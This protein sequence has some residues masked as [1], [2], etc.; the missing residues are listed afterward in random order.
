V[1]GGGDFSA[2]RI[3]P[4]CMAAFHQQLPVKIRRPNAIRP[5]QHVLDPLYGYLLLGAKLLDGQI[6]FAR[7]WNFGPY[8]ADIQSVEAIV[9]ILTSLWGDSARYECDTQTY[10]HEATLLQLDSS[11]AHTQLGWMPRWRIDEALAKT[12]EWYKLFY[13]GG[14]LF[15]L[16][17]AQIQA[18]TGI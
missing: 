12:C 8:N 14:D 17:Q 16:T 4:D 10:P 1:I 11:R 2:H 13:Q 15:K 5:W 7:S 9:K 3:I 18:Y 6:H